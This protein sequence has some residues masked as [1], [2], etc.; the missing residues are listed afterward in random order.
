MPDDD[1]A[2][3]HRSFPDLYVDVLWNLR[4]GARVLTATLPLVVERIA[5]HE[6]ATVLRDLWGQASHAEEQLSTVLSH[7]GG[8]ARMHAAEMETLIGV[9]MRRFGNWP[10]G[11]AHDVAASMVLRSAIHTAIP[12]C[13]LAIALAKAIG[14]PQHVR[15]LEA[16]RAQMQTTDDNLRRLSEQR[17]R[18]AHAATQGG[19]N[20]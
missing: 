4:A 19:K 3:E 7:F 14:F 12:G 9:A 1:L 18:Q 15:G 20:G 5:Y 13:E 17:I 6:I 8:P 10:R 2:E 16:L 11:D